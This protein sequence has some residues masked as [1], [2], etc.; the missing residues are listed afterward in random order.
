L[1]GLR[2]RTP[3][4]FPEHSRENFQNLKRLAQHIV[5]LVDRF[6]SGQVSKVHLDP[7]L[8]CRKWRVKVKTAN[9]SLTMGRLPNLFLFLRE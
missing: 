7:P 4:S 8:I 5:R 9:Q 1:T 6:K 3:S 2:A